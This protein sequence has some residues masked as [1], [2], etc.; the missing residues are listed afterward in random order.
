[1]RYYDRR[2]PEYEEIY[3]RNDPVRLGEL[4]RAAEVMGKKLRDRNVLEIACGTGYWTERLVAC[5]RSVMATDAS[6]DMLSLAR[7]KKLPKE[8]VMPWSPARE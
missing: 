2:A 7:K 4:D 6:A 5:A 1:M 3:Y 8:I